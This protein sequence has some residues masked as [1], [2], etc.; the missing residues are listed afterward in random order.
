MK[1]INK[2]FIAILSFSLVLVSCE[3]I[4]EVDPDNQIR[5]EDH[6]QTINDMRFASLGI[7]ASLRDAAERLVIVAGLKGE[8]VTTTSLGG[9][10]YVQIDNFN[11]TGQNS[12]VNPVVFFNIIVNCNDL[13][14]NAEE[15][16]ANDPESMSVQEYEAHLVSAHAARGWAYLNLAKLYGSAPYYTDPIRTLEDL[17]KPGLY[18]VLDFEGIVDK[19]LEDVAMVHSSFSVVELD[20]TGLLG[21]SDYS[22]NRMAM[23]I[24]PL[25]VELNLWKYAFSKNEEY[26]ENAFAPLLSIVGKTHNEHV[27]KVSSW[28]QDENWL[29]LFFNGVTAASNNENVV[30][31]R[32]NRLDNQRNG[33]QKVFSQGGSNTYQ[34][35]PTNYSV[36]SFVSQMRKSGGQMDI[37]RLAG[38]VRLGA[39]P[40][41]NKYSVGKDDFDHDGDIF[42]YR[43]GEMWLWMA[44]IFCGLGELDKSMV[45]INN[46]LNSVYKNSD[47][48]YPF[49]DSLYVF[50][51]ICKSNIGLRGRVG[52]APVSLTAYDYN[53]D[54]VIDA[55]DSTYIVQDFLLQETNLELAYEAKSWF[56]LMRMAILRDDPAFLANRVADSFENGEGEALRSKL[57]D[58]TQWFL[59]K[60]W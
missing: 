26:L 55:T 49:N 31:A 3:K 56:T 17:N 16:R 50:P 13:L 34:L 12:L 51:E 57:T 32:Y 20:W 7:T 18:S 35:K 53:E 11:A 52:L 37:H 38:S 10:E 2:F 48:E 58:N 40:E 47:F 15:Y 36:Q 33:L 60:F 42:I 4:L 30:G 46:G 6:Y 8:L 39:V 59:P 25:E 44:E 22:W 9:E 43:A 54:E 23:K 29:S 27:Q 14:A 21:L 45:L 19:L 41:V 24:S 1:R 28:F 5:E